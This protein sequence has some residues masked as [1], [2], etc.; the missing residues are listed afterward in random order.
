MVQALV[1]QH[2]GQAMEKP[3]AGGDSHGEP[4]LP[5]DPAQRAV[6]LRRR[7]LAAALDQ[8]LQV[9][10]GSLGHCAEPSPPLA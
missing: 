9:C 6:E 8:A 7:R 5:G 1:S 2:A 4:S 3:C 10:R